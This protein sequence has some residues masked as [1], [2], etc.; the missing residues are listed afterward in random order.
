MREKFGDQTYLNWMFARIRNRL[1]RSSRKPPVVV[2]GGVFD[3]AKV[4]EESDGPYLVD[5]RDPS[6]TVICGP[7]DE[8]VL[9]MLAPAHIGDA[10]TITLP[11]GRVLTGTEL[12][13]EQ[14]ALPG[15]PTWTW[16]DD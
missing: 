16:R 4:A 12:R 5:G 10:A 15:E 9:R 11:S 3:A 14:A 13:D 8:A 1:T 2:L 6:N 7:S